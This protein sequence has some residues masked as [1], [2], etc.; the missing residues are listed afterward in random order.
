MVLRLLGAAAT[1]LASSIGAGVSEVRPPAPRSVGVIPGISDDS[2]MT[3]LRDT[4]ESRI[5][6]ELAHLDHYIVDQVLTIVGG[7]DDPEAVTMITDS[8]VVS[9]KGKLRG[10]EKL[11]RAATNRSSLPALAFG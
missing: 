11:G 10:Y 4:I 1:F 2:N 7:G 5:P 6:V 8:V 3:Q 9:V